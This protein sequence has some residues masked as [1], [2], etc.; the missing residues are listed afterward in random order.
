MAT[1]VESR[2]LIPDRLL[3]DR[4]RRLQKLGP[5]RLKAA[6]TVRLEDHYLDTPGKALLHQGWACRLRSDGA[7]WTVT[8]KGPKEL[9]GAT[10]TRAEYETMLPGGIEDPV[11]WPAGEVRQRMLDLTSSMPLRR[12]VSIRQT[13]RCYRVTHSSRVVG[14]LTLDVVRSLGEGLEYRAYMLECELCETGT[15]GDL[16]TLHGL[17][18]DEFGLLAE[19]RSKLQRAL[20]LV[21][22]NRSPDVAL[23]S[24]RQP[25]SPEALVR[26]YGADVERA[27]WVADAAERLWELLAPARDLPPSQ[28]PL[29]RAAALLQELGQIS[30]RGSR[31][32][33]AR[34]LLLQTP[35]A[36]LDAEQQRVVAACAY[37]ARK[38]VDPRRVAEVIPDEWPEPARSQALAVAAVVRLAVALDRSDT[39]STR[40]HHVELRDG[41]VRLAVSGPAAFDD[42]RNA[43]RRGELWG[44]VS[45]V[46]LQWA[47]LDE[48]GAVLLEAPARSLGLQPWDAVPEAARKTLAYHLQRMLD[49][50]AGTREGA[51]PEDLHDM[52][53]AT[54]RMRSALRLFGTY[55]TGPLAVRANDDLRRLGRLLGGVRDLDVS[56]EGATQ[57]LATLPEGERYDLGPLIAMWQRQRTVAR[58][59]MLAYLNSRAYA[60]AVA[61]LRALLDRLAAPGVLV[62][63]E[64]SIGRVGPRLL[65]IL[66]QVVRSYDVVLPGAPPELLHALRIECKRLRYGIEFLSEVLPQRVVALIPEVVALQDHLGE[67]H[68]DAVTVRLLDDLLARHSGPR[69]AGLRAY[70]EDAQRDEEERLASTPTMW[71]HLMS[72][73]T[74]SAFSRLLSD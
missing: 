13:R 12:L 2:Y 41:V 63:E 19:G 10:H 11:R 27:A 23:L 6:G 38:A 61:N 48:D 47:V 64:Q 68:D 54:R 32:L 45:P 42:A 20:D 9:A 21:E 16:E 56:I 3:F 36:G 50:E 5:F 55:V 22:R 74:L 26:R 57:H 52:R 18:V 17:L 66:W 46:R 25:A 28:R 34:A 39:Q 30:R 31:P 62:P 29:V 1:E 8:L 67:L 72:R 44:L 60:R 58:R 15:V 71:A 59:R 4:L 35:I 69:H 37:L 7:N 40:L 51:D 65:H 53:V 49:H 43:A 14:E 33:A 73:E 24:D 70:R